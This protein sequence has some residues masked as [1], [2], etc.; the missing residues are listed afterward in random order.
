MFVVVIEVVVSPVSFVAAGAA[1]AG[2]GA[3][4]VLGAA[5]AAAV[6]AIAE[7]AGAEATAAG[8][9]CCCAGGTAGGG[10]AG[11]VEAVGIAVAVVADGR[12]NAPSSSDTTFPLCWN[13]MRM[14]LAFC[15]THCT[16]LVGG[17]ASKRGDK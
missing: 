17:L 4:A 10:T 2:A 12:D 1:G 15:Q 9:C 11:R 13:D 8:I 7:E 5:A 6:G 14:P 16:Y 3:E